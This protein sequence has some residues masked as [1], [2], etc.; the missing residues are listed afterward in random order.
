MKQT[1]SRTLR[2]AITKSN[3]DFVVYIKVYIY[4]YLN[5]K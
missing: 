5:A 1:D 2:C 3:R 4:V